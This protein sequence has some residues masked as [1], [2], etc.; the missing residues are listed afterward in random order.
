MCYYHD[1][2]GIH[3]MLMLCQGVGR[4]PLLHLDRRMVSNARKFCSHWERRSICRKRQVHFWGRVEGPE[5]RLWSV[6]QCVMDKG[7][8]NADCLLK[9][10]RPSG[11]PKHS[12]SV[13]FTTVM[14]AF[15]GQ[16]QTIKIIALLNLQEL[17]EQ[18]PDRH[19]WWD[20]MKHRGLKHHQK[21]QHTF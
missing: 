21:P 16:E 14:A 9:G 17:L 15:S 10:R 12:P 20:L 4:V 5:E 8:R 3:Q 18:S 13:N 7:L 19:A 1:A 6:P 11:I 2:R